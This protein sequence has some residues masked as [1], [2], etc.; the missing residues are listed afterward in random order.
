MHFACWN[1]N[2]RDRD[3]YISP[4]TFT[5]QVSLQFI[6][7][8]RY[9]YIG[10]RIIIIDS[11]RFR[12][13]SRHVVNVNVPLLYLWR[14]NKISAWQSKCTEF[15]NRLQLRKVRKRPSRYRRESTRRNGVG[16]K[17]DCAHNLRNYT[18]VVCKPVT[19]IIV[20]LNARAYTRRK[21]IMRPWSLRAAAPSGGLRGNRVQSGL[22]NFNANTW[23]NSKLTRK[24]LT[25]L[26]DTA[27]QLQVAELNGIE[28]RIVPS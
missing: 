14:V 18:S 25:P 10:E 23:R 13:A 1:K 9:R 3:T 8:I 28:S 15:P 6:F 2:I 20:N 27:G 21:C 22:W 11:K 17:H 5:V 26:P 16:S 7:N 19:E 4:S 12:V 24:D